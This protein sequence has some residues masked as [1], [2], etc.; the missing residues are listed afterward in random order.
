M[1]NTVLRLQI[2]ATAIYVYKNATD[3]FD[4]TAFSEHLN[5]RDVSFRWEGGKISL[6]EEHKAI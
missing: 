1:V 5:W 3:I 6:W 2:T 4:K